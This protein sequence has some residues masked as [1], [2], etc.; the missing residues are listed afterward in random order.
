MEL[1]QQQ[2][3]QSLDIIAKTSEKTRRIIAAEYTAPSLMLWGVI[4][5]AAFIGS[6]FFIK[7]AGMIWLALDV[8]GIVGM[9]VIFNLQKRKSTPI[10]VANTNK[11]GRNIGIFWGLFFVYIIIWVAIL[12]PH[13]GKQQNA[14]ICL[15]IMFG[16]ITLGLWLESYYMLW[17]GLTATAT[18]L[19]C[20]YVVPSSFYCLAMAATFGGLL[21]GTGLYI[22][23]FWK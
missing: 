20:F 11:T 9:T 17:L 19:I 18:T 21:F 23:L 5:I 7:K 8:V 10:K 13:S 22:R 14:F 4:A 6:H 16:F 15:A 2:A 1:S 3:S 12:A